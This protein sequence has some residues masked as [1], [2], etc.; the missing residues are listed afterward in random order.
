MITLTFATFTVYLQT[1][2]ALNPKN[3]RRRQTSSS[4]FVTFCEPRF[5][6][7][8]DSNFILLWICPDGETEPSPEELLSV[9][10]FLLEQ[11]AV[12]T[13][14]PPNGEEIEQPTASPLPDTEYVMIHY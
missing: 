5:Y 13:C 11:N 14:Q 8:E 6:Q 7:T 10:A 3:R 2:Q 4:T 9:C 1:C 12:Q